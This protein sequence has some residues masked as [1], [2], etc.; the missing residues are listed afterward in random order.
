MRLLIAVPSK[1]RY[2]E[3][4][5]IR[6]TFSWLQYSE[7]DFK[8]FVEPSEYENYCKAVGAKNVV[9]V[10]KNNINIGGSKCY[11]Q[12]WALEHGYDLIL[13]CDDDIWNWRDFKNGWFPYQGKTSGIPMKERKRACAEFVFDKA[14]EDSIQLFEQRPDVGCVSYFYG[15]MMFH[16]PGTKW[17]TFNCRP[18]TVYMT[19]AEL[20]APERQSEIHQFEE[21]YSWYNMRKLGYVCPRYGLAGFHIDGNYASN[22]GGLQDFIRRKMTIES[23]KI[24]NEIWPGE[25]IY[26]KD[27]GD[28]GFFMTHNTRKIELCKPIPVPDDLI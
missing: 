2:R 3:D 22:S 8:I 4:Q 12:K 14:M 11:I 20:L 17:T 10:E 16:K 1:N 9:S 19:R 15:Q 26:K 6:N 27:N 13:K 5:I 24:L 7:Y 23:M 18:A 28:G 21:F 25:L